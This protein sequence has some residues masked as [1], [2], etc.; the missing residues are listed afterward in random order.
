V[1]AVTRGKGWTIL[2]ELYV[3][4]HL[5]GKGLQIVELYDPV[6]RHAV[7]LVQLARR[8]LGMAAQAFTGLCRETIKTLVDQ[9]RGLARLG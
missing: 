1:E 8:H 2:P 9:T 7:G 5:R 3:R 4:H 6:P